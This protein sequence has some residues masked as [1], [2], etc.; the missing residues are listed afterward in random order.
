M[1]AEH[2]LSQVC[3]VCTVCH[4]PGLSELGWTQKSENISR[5]NILVRALE[6]RSL[7]YSEPPWVYS[8]IL[9]ILPLGRFCVPGKFIF[10]YLRFW[11]PKK[12]KLLIIKITLSSGRLGGRG[13]I[14]SLYVTSGVFCFAFFPLNSRNCFYFFGWIPNAITGCHLAESV[15]FKIRK[16]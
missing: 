10:S 5:E 4:Q 2:R 11:N 16:S 3:A 1:E 6:G 8:H 13:L 7:S 15:S 12:K 14:T 9:L